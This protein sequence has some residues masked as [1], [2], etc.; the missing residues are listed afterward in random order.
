MWSPSSGKR[1]SFQQ[2][3]LVSDVAL[4]AEKTDAN[5]VNCWGIVAVAAGAPPPKSCHKQEPAPFWVANNGTST[6]VWSTHPEAPVT[7]D[8]E[9]PTGLVVNDTLL[10]QV[11]QNPLSPGL[12]SEL[13]TVTETGAIL[14]FNATV[15]PANAIVTVAP[16]GAKVFKGAALLASLLYVANFHDGVVEVYNGSWALVNTFT[17]AALLATGYAPFNVAAI[18]GQLYVSFARQDGDAH[19]DVP[20]VGSGYVDVFSGE[21]ELERRLINR[22]ALNSPWAMLELPS[23]ACG[24]GGG[25][26]RVLAVGNFG[27]GR[28][29][30]FD[31][32]DGTFLGPVADCLGNPVSIDGLWGVADAAAAVHQRHGRGGSREL[33]FAAGINN[34]ND[35]LVGK[36]A[37]CVPPSTSPLS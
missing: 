11:R 30:A 2:T 3:N 34:E 24:G 33:F 15:D 10:F 20:G 27:D 31:L 4:V 32:C 7:V 5:F 8:P 13:I 1:T 14:G 19:D 26:K 28:L 18:R 25:G 21:G 9:G 29:N 22:G 17:D 12:P 6:L 35:G 23:P 36:L 37:A 16:T